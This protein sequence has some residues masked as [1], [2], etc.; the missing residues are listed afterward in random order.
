MRVWE[1]FLSERDR[2]HMAKLPEPPR[3]GFGRTP[4]LLLIDNYKAG[5]GEEPLPLL[6]SIEKYPLSMGLEAWDAVKHA[7]RLLDSCRR[8]DLPIVHTTMLAEPN[9]PWEFYSVLRLNAQTR[10][11]ERIS[12]TINPDA[13]GDIFEIVPELAPLDNE[14]VIRKLAPS[15]FWGTPLVSFLQSEQVDTLLVCGESTSGCVRATVIDAA[16]HCFRT[17]VVEECVYDRTEAAHALNLFDMHQKYADVVGIEEVC[18]W[19][20]GRPLP[21]QTAATVLQGAE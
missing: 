3:V 11:R 8:L 15:A 10:T 2:A 14:V 12:Q 20:E 21:D 4:A 5:L 6:E 18:Q 7:R 17:I 19:L 1:P 9:S 16:S 13:K